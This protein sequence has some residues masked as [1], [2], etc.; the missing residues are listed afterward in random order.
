MPAVQ[1][2]LVATDFSAEAVHA[3]GRAGRIAR[4]FGCDRG[5][6]AHVQEA[7]SLAALKHL[8]GGS[9]PD[10]EGAR[11]SLEARLKSVAD[12]VA[13]EH[14]FRLEPEL[15]AG[16][17]LTELTRMAADH[18]LVAL[19]ARGIHQIRERLVGTLPQRLLGRIHKPLLV[20]RRAPDN[21]YGP[22]VVGVDFSDDAR[23]AVEWA[24]AI[25]PDAQLHLVH[26]FRHSQELAMHYANV[27]PK[28]IAVYRQR[29]REQSKAELDDFA[30]A[31]RLPAERVTSWVEEG[32]PAR[33]LCK[34]AAEVD[35]Q[36]IVVGKR[37]TS[38]AEDLVFGSVVQRLLGE[39]EFDLLVTPHR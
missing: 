37:G 2:I 22:V 33:A 39:A 27:T 10:Q 32:D 19:G 9:A 5:T 14:G 3:A 6:L 23:R 34:R 13:R 31:T 25:A 17:A 18:D 21:D 15:S 26:V 29:A 36:L 24:E 4:V 1:S 12:A 35:A 20:I 30:A 7:D 11:R 16:R 28:L 38:E 8:L